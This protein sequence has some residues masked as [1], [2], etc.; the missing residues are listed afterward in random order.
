LLRI[1]DSGKGFDYKNQDYRQLQDT[2]LSG[3]GIM[4]IRDLCESLEYHGKGNIA[5]ARF[6]WSTG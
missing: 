4:L 6:S 5:I 1:E 3:R 2:D